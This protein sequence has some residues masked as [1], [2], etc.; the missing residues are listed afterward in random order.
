MTHL[1]NQLKFEVNC[2]DEEQA[3]QLRHS[4]QDTLQEQIMK[5]VDG[6][7]SSYVP[8]DEW[9]QIDR[10]EIDAGSFSSHSLYSDFW[11]VFQK[12]F[13]EELVK[14]LSTI[15]AH[16]RNTSRQD[17]WVALFTHFLESGSLPWWATETEVDI[18]K[19]S[20]EIFMTQPEVL[21]QFF[22]TKR[23][24][25][26]VWR[27]AAFQL[28]AKANTR[29]VSFFETLVNAKKIF[30]SWATSLG[31][32]LQINDRPATNPCII[33]NIVVRNGPLILEETETAKLLRRIFTDHL[34][35]IISPPADTP[36]AQ[37]SEMLQ[38]IVK[39]EPFSG[40]TQEQD[41]KE[42]I[43]RNKKPAEEYRSEET[44]KYIAREAGIILLSPFFKQLFLKLQLY[45]NAGWTSKEAPWRAVH[46]I[47][48]LATGQQQ[49]PEYTLV[50]EKLLCGLLPGEPVPMQISLTDKEMQEATI[51]LES[52]L[53]HWKALRN[54]S[55]TG[56]RETFFKRDGLITRKDNGWLLQVERKTLDVLLDSLPWGYSA[57]RLP[58]NDYVI[59]TEW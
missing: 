25:P 16:K 20:D 24:Q 46:I 5:A 12:K 27:R 42:S 50:L 44:L 33:D 21:R 10:I 56:L 38:A 30:T 7:C 47:K 6:L 18:K 9:I 37:I 58:W 32:K 48:F 49:Q 3:F 23:F 31:D 14:K 1:V 29:I 13:E 54:T 39:A 40:F 43:D 36:F 2:R 51:L 8:G 26:D 28:D 41:I 52:V 34:E 55:I 15:P 59:Y 4:F 11:F 19:I 22:Y 17:S 53:E 45:D 57:V 35:E